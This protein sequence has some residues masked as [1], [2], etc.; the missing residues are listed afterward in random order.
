MEKD[1]LI[2]LLGLCMKDQGFVITN[3]FWAKILVSGITSDDIKEIQSTLKQLGK[4]LI[5]ASEHIK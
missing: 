3:Y 2:Q 4:A 1:E 5:D